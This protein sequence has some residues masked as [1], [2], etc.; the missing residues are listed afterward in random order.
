METVGCD[1]W[2]VLVG[3][4]REA[5]LVH[6][7]PSCVGGGAGE[8]G[9]FVVGKGAAGGVPA[10]AGVARVVAFQG[11]GEDD[12]DVGSGEFFYL[13][14]ELAYG[15]VEGVGACGVLIVAE[16]AEGYVALEVV[17]DEVDGPDGVLYVGPSVVGL[18]CNYCD[19]LVV[20][21]A[22]ASQRIAAVASI[23]TWGGDGGE[24]EGFAD[25]C[26]IASSAKDACEGGDEGS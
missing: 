13:V 14:V 10:C 18:L 11:I 16:G 1:G 23:G 8:Q 15:S 3:D 2:Q 26:L 17:G 22:D 20:C 6:E 24:V 9:Q 4:A 5:V 25:E 7:V 19:A 21:G 12:D